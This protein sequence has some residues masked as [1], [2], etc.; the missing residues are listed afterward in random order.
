MK[1][2]N[3]KTM[4]NQQHDETINQLKEEL[5]PLINDSYYT[6]R[7]NRD[8]AQMLT[9]V[10]LCFGENPEISI[11][12]FLSHAIQVMN[13][14]KKVEREDL[15]ERWEKVISMLYQLQGPTEEIPHV[16]VVDREE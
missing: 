12:N 6:V 4:N 14:L 5:P 2:S 1:I 7:D 15:V 9:K 3:Y 10:C 16:S 8:A 11:Q 13:Y